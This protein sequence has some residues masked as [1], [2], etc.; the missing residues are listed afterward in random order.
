MNHY[1][2]SAA[3]NEKNKLVNAVYVYNHMKLQL[4]INFYENQNNLII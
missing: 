3:L 4:A 1:N 2:L